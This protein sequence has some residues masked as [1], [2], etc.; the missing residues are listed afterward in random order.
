MDVVTGVWQWFADGENWSGSNGI[1]QR[2]LEHF[3]ISGWALLLAFAVA[4]PAGIVVGHT[5]RFGALVTNIG[6]LGRAIPTFAVLVILASWEAVGV[7]DLAAILALAVFA[8]PPVLTNTY[9]GVRD[10]DP[11]ALDSARG[12]GMTG[13]QVL[14]RVELPLAVPLI[15]AGI[16]TAT[17]QVVAT[18]TLAAL[19][20]GGGLGRYVVDGFGLQDTTL[21][22]AG[23]VL[24]A[25]VCIVVEL[26][27][28]AAQRAVTP[29]PLRSGA[30]DV[31]GDF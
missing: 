25:V 11:Q 26:V 24:V 23:V 22:F 3:V 13:G 18:A 7:S 28:S 1:P 17:V 27:L 21:L 6:N 4:L 9:V 2:L 10:V 14:R 31:L 29:P 30:A 19:V 5:R 12:L 20:G 16:R 8:V 15:A